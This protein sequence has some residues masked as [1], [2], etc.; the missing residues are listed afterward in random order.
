MAKE[1]LIVLL[2]HSV[3]IDSV[4]VG[5]ERQL[6]LHIF[7]IDDPGEDIEEHLR[8]MTPGL[9]IFELED[10]G[11]SSLLNLLKDQTR[12]S[13]LGLDR[14][15]SQAIVLNIYPKATRTMNELVCIVQTIVREGASQSEG[16]NLTRI[17]GKKSTLA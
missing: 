7:R 15:C 6:N 17:D 12:I 4:A 11:S 2:G 14:H 8:S 16:G 1:P 10:T 9:V 3:L 13:L 5:L